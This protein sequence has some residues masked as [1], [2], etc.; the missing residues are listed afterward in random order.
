MNTDFV[1]RTGPFD[2]TS[3]TPSSDEEARSLALKRYDTLV[4]TSG[5]LLISGSGDHTL[6]L[7]LVPF[8]HD[9]DRGIRVRSGEG[10]EIEAVGE[11]D[12]SPE[13]G[14]ACCV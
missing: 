12:G 5:E 6:P 4:S 2:R 13:A 9:V 7:V 11:A 3:K 10:W 14:C 1:L 8:T